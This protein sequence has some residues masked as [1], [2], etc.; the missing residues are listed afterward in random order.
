MTARPDTPT[1]SDS[2]LWKRRSRRGHQ[3]PFLQSQGSWVIPGSLQDGPF[4]LYGTFKRWHGQTKKRTSS[5]HP[6]GTSSHASALVRGPSNVRQV[7]TNLSELDLAY[8]TVQ[9]MLNVLHRKGRA[10]RTLK[11]RAFHYR[12]LVSKETVLRKA[13]SDLVERVFGG[14]SEELVMRL[15]KSRQVDPERIAELSRTLAAER[16]AVRA[17]RAALLLKE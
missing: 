4:E 1:C 5:P 10:R 2:K 11:G 13:V 17:R 14:S 15:I 6:S 9:T 7:Q 12:A 16:A 8:T 3:C